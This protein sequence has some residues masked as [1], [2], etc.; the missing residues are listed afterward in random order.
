M[1]LI[2]EPFIVCQNC[3]EK[4]STKSG[5]C[6]KCGA[7]LPL[8]KKPR[9]EQEKDL[10]P[11][12]FHSLSI[13]EK[14]W[15]WVWEKWDEKNRSAKNSIIG[16]TGI[17]G[18]IGILA[19]ISGLVSISSDVDFGLERIGAGIFIVIIGLFLGIFMLLAD[20]NGV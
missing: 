3:G 7:K 10:L 18:I 5:F 15:L 8:E 6:V 11:R 19:V 13:K 1:G 17:I 2:M 4:S 20:W 9:Q 14:I 12:T 16:I